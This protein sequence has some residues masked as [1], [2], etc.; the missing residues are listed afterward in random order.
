MTVIAL[1]LL[2]PFSANSQTIEIKGIQIGLPKE[3]V[4]Q[5][6]P[7]SDAFTIAGVKSKFDMIPYS[8]KYR[9]GLLDR[10]AFYFH[11]RSFENVLGAVKEKYPKISCVSSPV[12]NAMGASFEQIQ[13]SLKGTDSILE[14]RRYAGVIDTSALTLT[15]FKFIEDE[16]EKEKNKKKD[17]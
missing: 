3:Q 16:N 11:S 1:A 4:E 15:S 14:L 17:I 5:K 10:F 2:L 9:D 7:D 6:A 12:G 8:T 13:C